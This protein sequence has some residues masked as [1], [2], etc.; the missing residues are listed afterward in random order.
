M[1]NVASRILGILS[2]ELDLEPEHLSVD[3]SFHFSEF[4]TALDDEFDLL[5]GAVVYEFM[6]VR[7]MASRIERVLA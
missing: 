3:H 5:S 6:S 1:N 7:D 2:T 4:E